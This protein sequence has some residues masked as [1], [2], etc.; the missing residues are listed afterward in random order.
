MYNQSPETP[1]ATRFVR[2]QRGDDVPYIIDNHEGS[3]SL[4]EALRLLMGRGDWADLATG[5]LSLGGYQLLRDALTGLQDLRLLL[6]E[7][8][9]EAE[10]QRY[11]LEEA[12][13]AALVPASK[14]IT[15]DDLQLVCWMMI[16]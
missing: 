7:S 11:A 3:P 10:L 5:Y 2:E 15:R 9:I 6:G 13:A 8:T 14:P 16:R 4:A 1:P 12:A